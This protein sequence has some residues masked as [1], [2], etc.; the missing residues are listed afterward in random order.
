MRNPLSDSTSTT[1]P[2]VVTTLEHP[3]IFPGFSI[4]TSASLFT[5]ERSNQPEAWSGPLGKLLGARPVERASKNGSP[6]FSMARYAPGA[7]RSNENVE[8]ITGI[9]L[10]FDHVSPED[11]CH[12]YHQVQCRFAG[13]LHT[14]FSDLAGGSHDRCARLVLPATRE[15]LKAEAKV[16]RNVI[17]RSLGVKTDDT[18]ADPAR[19]WYLP[20]A[21]V[22]ATNGRYIGYLFGKVLDPDMI[23]AAAQPEAA[24]AAPAEQRNDWRSLAANGATPGGRHGALLSFAAHLLGKGVD[25]VVA[26]DLLRAWNVAKNLPPKPDAEVVAIVN[27][28]AG[29]ELKKLEVRH[30]R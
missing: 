26:L 23:M 18:T 24:T 15:M 8:A 4:A 5:T 10:D 28:I 17:A 11:L 20:S 22:R 6:C 21:P 13:A 27:Y 29:R 1:Q 12:V 16:V 30:G 14:T 3:S 9:V 19:L 7:T 25:P 2:L